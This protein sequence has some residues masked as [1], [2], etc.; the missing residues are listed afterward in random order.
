MI[1]SFYN[2]VAPIS[3]YKNDII[4]TTIVYKIKCGKE[5]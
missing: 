3:Y 5:M 1:I 4:E 2:K